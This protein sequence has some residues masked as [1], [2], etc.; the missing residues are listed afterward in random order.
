M[1]REFIYYMHGTTKSYGG[2]KKVLDNIHLQFY[3]DAKIGVLGPNGSGK[4]TL[5]KIMAGL[6][7]EFTGEAWLA[8]GATVGYLSQEPQLDPT[9]DVFGNVMLGVAKDKALIDAIQR[10][11]DGLLGRERREGHQDSGHHRR[12][13]PV[14]SRQQGRDGDG[15]AAL[16]AGRRRRHHAVGR[17]APPRGSRQAAPGE[18]RPPAARR[19]DQPSRRRVG[20]LAGKA[21][22]RVPWRRLDRHPRSLLPRQRHRLDSRAGPWSRHSLRGQ[23]LGLSHGQVQAPRAGRPRGPP[24]SSAPWSASAS[25][26]APAPRPVRPSRRPRIKSYD[27]LLRRNEERQDGHQRPR[28]SF[29]PARAS[30]TTSS[31]SKAFPRAMAIACSS[32]TFP[33]RCPPGGIVGIIGPNGAGKT[34]LFR[35]ITGQ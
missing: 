1:A 17:R 20:G 25:G 10:A 19:A 13:E 2:G 22:A 15:R 26:S 12:Q 24:P 30:A 3:P 33:S 6:D 9:L 18:P 35:M 11:D 28:S 4:S 29:R 32:R 16:P 23:L 7:K 27:E 14:G 5:L 8:K 31:R 34:T 21:S